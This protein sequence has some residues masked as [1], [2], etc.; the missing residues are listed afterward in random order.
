MNRKVTFQKK[1]KSKNCM[2]DETWEDD[3]TT[4]ADIQDIDLIERQT[5]KDTIKSEIEKT[6]LVR[7]SSKT[8]PLFKPSG[9]LEYRIILDGFSYEIKSIWE[10]LK[11]VGYIK[12]KCKTVM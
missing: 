10:D 9:I 11:K 2:S 3:F 4:W 5:E 8:D 12:I 1:I 6:F 7:K